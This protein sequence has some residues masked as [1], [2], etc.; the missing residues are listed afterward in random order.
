MSDTIRPAISSDEVRVIKA[1]GILDFQ[2]AHKFD[3]E[4]TSAINSGSRFI[5]LNMS[6]VSQI[7]SAALG[8]IIA[9]NTDVR[10]VGGEIKISSLPGEVRK[11]F[12]L[13]SFDK[14]FKIYDGDEDA[15]KS[16]AH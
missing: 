15:V 12:E 5:V 16:F 3:A 8:V 10:K 6:T 2:G 11:V 9:R 4:L 13:V 1:D 14:V 7:S